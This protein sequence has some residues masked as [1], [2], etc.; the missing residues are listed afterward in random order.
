MGD[1]GE[2]KKWGGKSGKMQGRHH[3]RF[4]EET[5]GF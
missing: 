2:R 5:G 3:A 4:A 1:P